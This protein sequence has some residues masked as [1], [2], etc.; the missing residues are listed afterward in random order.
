MFSVLWPWTKSSVCKYFSVWLR[1]IMLFI[2]TIIMAGFRW[3]KNRSWHALIH[4]HTTYKENFASSFLSLNSKLQ[5][6][7]INSCDFIP[8]LIDFTWKFH[9]DFCLG[10]N[11]RLVVPV[12]ALLWNFVGNLKTELR[13]KTK[14]TTTAVIQ[15]TEQHQLLLFVL[16]CFV[17]P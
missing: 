1:V 12:S 14:S 17:F 10:K 2:S 9:P 16:F 7:K 8:A 3:S 6:L 15:H 4:K 11:C 5:G 13:H